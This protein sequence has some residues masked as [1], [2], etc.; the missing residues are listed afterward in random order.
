MGGCRC[1]C[2][3]LRRVNEC[4]R[5]GAVGWVVGCWC[6]FVMQLLDS[7]FIPSHSWTCLSTLH[8]W[9][10]S[11]LTHTDT[12]TYTHTHTHNTHTHAHT[13]T[14]KHT[15]TQTHKHTQT[16]PHTQTH[17]NTHT[18]TFHTLTAVLQ[19]LFN[20]LLIQIITKMLGVWDC[21][22]IDL[23]DLEI[24]PSAI[25]LLTKGHL[26]KGDPYPGQ[27]ELLQQVCGCICLCA[28][29]R[30]CVHLCIS[31]CV[32]VC[33][34]MHMYISVWECACISMHV[35]VCVCVSEGWEGE[36][37]VGSFGL[38]VSKTKMMCY[39]LEKCDQSL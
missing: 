10:A 32:C 20:P 1:G 38:V 28:R 14:H 16:H 2:R 13:Q 24:L 23:H 4:A 22:E 9:F 6:A 26:G 12:H 34:C 19:I 21:E 8:F 18:H 5:A 11:A 3:G 15:Q 37:V 27:T 7:R 25:A 33:V 30:E 35:Y 17:T 29:V 39:V 31:V 36:K